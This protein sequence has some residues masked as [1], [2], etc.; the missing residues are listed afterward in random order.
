MLLKIVRLLGKTFFVG[1]SLNMFGLDFLTFS[2]HDAEGNLI[3]HKEDVRIKCWLFPFPCVFHYNDGGDT[4]SRPFFRIIKEL[5][6]ADIPD[7]LKTFL[8]EQVITSD[9]IQY[10]EACCIPLQATMNYFTHPWAMDRMVENRIVSVASGMFEP[11]NLS[12]INGEIGVNTVVAQDMNFHDSVYLSGNVARFQMDDF[13]K[14]AK[15]WFVSV[16]D[17]AVNARK[18]AECNQVKRAIIV[19]WHFIPDQCYAELLSGELY[20]EMP[21]MKPNETLHPPFIPQK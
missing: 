15:A 10:F 3:Y 21:D 17:P 19:Y 9:Q 4:S 2:S 6:A 7:P 5:S 18:N 13:S 1:F 12:P 8:T 16:Y 20:V 11:E 14:P